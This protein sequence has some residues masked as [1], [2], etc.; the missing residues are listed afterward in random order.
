M[1]PALL[2]WAPPASNGGSAIADYVITPYLG[3]TAL[4]K[5]VVGAVLQTTVTGLTNKQTY[6]FT[7]A[8]TNAS[9]TA[10]AK[11]AIASPR[12]RRSLRGA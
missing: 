5:R 9:G 11:R 12:V 2:R 10:R 3:S 6:T 4:P 1:R 8:A 7:V